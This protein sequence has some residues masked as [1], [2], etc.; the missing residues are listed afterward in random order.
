MFWNRRTMLT[1][2]LGSFGSLLL[3]S[4]ALARRSSAA[5]ASASGPLI[6]DNRVALV[7]GTQRYQYHDQIGTA[8]NDARAMGR[9]LT[10]QGGFSLVGDRVHVDR[11][12][13]ELRNLIG[14]FLDAAEHADLAVVYLAGHCERRPSDQQL[15]YLA[16]SARG[17]RAT[18]LHNE[19]LG[20]HDDLLTPAAD[21]LARNPRLRLVTMVDNYVAPTLSLIHI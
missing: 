4:E 15:F 3:G 16:M 12:Q 21:V 14:A 18:A 5:P 7:I 19:A 11:R 1:T 20:L 17:D 6:R 8:Y 9:A 13:A 10:E 2:G